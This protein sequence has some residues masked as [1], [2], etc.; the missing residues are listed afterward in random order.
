VLCSLHVNGC[1]SFEEQPFTCKEHDTSNERQPFTCKEH[2]SSKERQPFT[3]KEHNT[4][5]KKGSHLH[6]R[7]TVVLLTCKWLPFFW[8][9]SCSLHVN[10]CL[11]FEECRAPYM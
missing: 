6:V 5:Q 7:S 4:L 11:S 2:N 1:L 3:C 10:G 9:V 8:R